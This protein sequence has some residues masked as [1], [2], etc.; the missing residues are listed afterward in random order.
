MATATLM[1]AVLLMSRD[2]A[3]HHQ[4]WHAAAWGLRGS[5]R[6]YSTRRW[7]PLCLQEE[8]CISAVR[9]WIAQS[10]CF[11]GWA[12]E[13]G[14]CKLWVVRGWLERT[15]EE[16]SMLRCLHLNKC[17]LMLESC[18]STSAQ[19]PKGSHGW[20]HRSSGAIATFTRLLV[21]L[22]HEIARDRISYVCFACS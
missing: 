16:W 2:Q 10:A 15:A 22:I 21:T 4:R 20:R 12:T 8:C 5:S 7:S 14:R 9:Y 18:L 1:R 19:G 6:A 3:Q 13:S 17:I 11:L